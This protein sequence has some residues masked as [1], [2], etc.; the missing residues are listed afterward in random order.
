MNCHQRFQNILLFLQKRRQCGVF[1]LT[2]LPGRLHRAKGFTL[3]ELL[4]SLAILGMIATFTVPKIL[5]A[6]QSA[7][8]AAV[9]KETVATIN[10]VLYQGYAYDGM[11]QA[12]VGTYIR[13]HVN[14]IKICNSNAGTQGCWDTTIQGTNTGQE[15][16]P[17]LVLPNGATLAGLDDC[18]GNGF[19]GM[20]AGEASG[21]FAIDLNGLEGPNQLNQD[22][23]LL[24]ACFGTVS[25]TT[26]LTGPPGKI[27]IP[28]AA[29]SFFQ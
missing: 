15:G 4:V 8:N 3:A 11:T 24:Y 6:Q 5:Y 17:G 2:S 28:A 25:C 7:K 14:A 29:Q 23:F 27:T 19:G 26:W 20:A 12:N 22:Q 21:N 13:S 9:F 16:E 10:A 1:K 18:C